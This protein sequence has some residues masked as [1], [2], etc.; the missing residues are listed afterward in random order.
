MTHHDVY[1]DGRIHVL[2][3]RCATCIF[4]PGDLMHLQPGRVKEMVTSAIRN[5]S[6]IPC[7]STI[8]DPAVKPAICRGYW[9]AYRNEVVALRLAQVMDIV[10]EDPA[11]PKEGP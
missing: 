5:E 3:D 10:V 4:R 2:N 9:D 11:P 7:H 6:V 1:R 8:Y